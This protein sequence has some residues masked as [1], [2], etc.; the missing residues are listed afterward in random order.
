MEPTPSKEPRTYVKNNDVA[1]IFKSVIHALDLK[2]YEFAD[3]M[4]MGKQVAYDYTMGKK[5]PNWER[6]AKIKEV[7]PQVSGDFLLTGK[8]SVLKE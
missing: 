2:V 6:L 1:H 7:F 3:Q 4:G 5:S 8:G